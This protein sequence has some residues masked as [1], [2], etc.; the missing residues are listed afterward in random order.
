[1]ITVGLLLNILALLAFGAAFVMAL[2][3]V[4]GPAVAFIALGLALLV[5]AKL[6]GVS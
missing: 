6:L 1:M 2:P 3:R 4:G 5:V